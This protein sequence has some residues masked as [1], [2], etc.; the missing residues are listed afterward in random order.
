M[1]ELTIIAAIWAISLLVCVILF[2]PIVKSRYWQADQ[3]QRDGMEELS[4]TSETVS[5]F[6]LQRGNISVAS[7]SL[8]PGLIDYCFPHAPCGPMR[9]TRPARMNRL[10]C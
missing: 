4:S 8:M 6:V 2:W 5:L 10:G 9:K 7:L 1:T 3:H